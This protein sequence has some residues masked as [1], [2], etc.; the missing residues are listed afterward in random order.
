MY[1]LYKVT[2]SYNIITPGRMYEFKSLTKVVADR[3][4]NNPRVVKVTKVIRPKG[5]SEIGIFPNKKFKWNQDNFGP[6]Y[7]PQKG[8]TIVL[9]KEV[10]PLYKRIIEVYENNTITLDRNRIQIN[11]K[12]VTQYTFKQNYYWGMGD[13]RHNSEDSRNW[14]YIPEDHIVG[15]VVFIWFSWDKHAKDIMN[16][17]RWDRLFTTVEGDTPPRSYFI[18]FIL[19][20]IGYIVFIRY[21]KKVSEN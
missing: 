13:N 6:I 8:N 4:A 18:Y 21:K 5:Q 7:I 11:G 14:G 2:G 9:N 19:L 15:K 20:V 3:L 16:K 1:R 17:I 12:D 10:L